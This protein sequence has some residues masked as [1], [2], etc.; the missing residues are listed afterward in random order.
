MIKRK[1]INFI[2]SDVLHHPDYPLQ[3]E[4]PL[5]TGGLMDS[6]SLTNLAVFI[7]TELG[8][9]IPDS[10]FTVEQMDTVDLIMAQI[11]KAK[12]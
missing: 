1:L 8:V 3:G 9:Y 11:K 4:E 6:F 5:I 2:C 7:E 12:E 10:E